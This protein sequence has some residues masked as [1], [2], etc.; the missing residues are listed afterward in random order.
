MV[1]PNED[2]AYGFIPNTVYKI[3]DLKRY[4]SD[5]RASKAETF[6]VRYVPDLRD[7]VVGEA[8]GRTGHLRR[9][10]TGP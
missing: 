3:E 8:C 10:S 1:D 9:V 6:A 2:E 4:L 5:M 7:L